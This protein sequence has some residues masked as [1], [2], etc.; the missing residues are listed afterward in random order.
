MTVPTSNINL[1]ADINA[2]VSTVN[3]TSLTTLAGNAIS[4]TGGNSPVLTDSLPTPSPHGIREFAGYTHIQNQSITYTQSMRHGSTYST[5]AL[6]QSGADV[7]CIMGAVGTQYRIYIT[8]STTTGK[9]IIKLQAVSGTSLKY[10]TTGASSSAGSSQF[11]VGTAQIP[12]PYT[13]NNVDQIRLNHSATAWSSSY[14]DMFNNYAYNSVAGATLLTRDAFQTANGNSVTYGV[15]HA[16]MGQK[17]EGSS[18]SHNRTD[19]YS[20]TFRRSGYYDYTTPS[21]SVRTIHSY[22]RQCGGF[23]NNCLHE[24]MKVWLKGKDNL[25]FTPVKEVVVGDMV[26]TKDGKY[27]KVTKVVTDHMREGYYTLLDGLKITGDHPIV[28]HR[29]E[30]EITPETPW[31]RVDEVDLPKEYVDG[32]VPTVYIETESGDMH[33]YWQQPNHNNRWEACLVSASYGNL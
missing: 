10:S 3:S 31:R 4:Y 32:P 23:G 20:L 29:Y 25:D 9:Y 16:Y 26:R 28:P 14:P 21:F 18:S 13:T 15:Q 1:S 30:N 12:S 24:D 8:W 22:V 2:E 19:T 17:E 33:T 27:T 6:Q 11:T 5:A 7:Y